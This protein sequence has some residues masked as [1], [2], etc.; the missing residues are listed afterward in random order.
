MGIILIRNNS[1]SNDKIKQKKEK[2]IRK[3]REYR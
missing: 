2:I 1:L 3:F